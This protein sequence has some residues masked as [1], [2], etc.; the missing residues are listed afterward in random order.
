MGDVRIVPLF[1]IHHVD[2]SWC[3]YNYTDTGTGTFADLARGRRVSALSRL[4]SRPHQTV[5]YRCQALQTH[6]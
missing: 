4:V 5:A 6:D 3:Y 2:I 1:D